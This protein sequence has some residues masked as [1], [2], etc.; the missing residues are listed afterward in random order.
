[1]GWGTL[2]KSFQETMKKFDE[3]ANE[4]LQTRQ[5]VIDL[6][7]SIERID[8]QNQRLQI[9]AIIV[10]GIG[11]TLSVIGAIDVILRLTA[12]R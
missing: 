12:T 3:L 11:V 1:M 6:R 2:D 4:L 8:K 10:S 9:M 5:A 7:K